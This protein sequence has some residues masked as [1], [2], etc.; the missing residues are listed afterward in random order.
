MSI[1]KKSV[2]F[3]LSAII[4]GCTPQKHAD[5]TSDNSRYQW[6][7]IRQ[8]I[9]R[10]PEHALAMVDTAYMK[11][12]ADVNYANWMRA[13]IYYSSPKVTD[14]DKARELCIA[15][16]ENKNPEPDSLRKLRTLSLLTGVC[17]NHPDTYQDAVHYAIRGAEMAHRAGDIQQE[18]DF[19]FQAGK[20]M[21]RL[22][23]G[24]GFE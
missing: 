23:R 3:L 6:E 1:M 17:A 7:N 15:I 12:L 19:Y 21:E 20:V 13:V 4:L 9:L 24:S 10:E 14:Y 8:Y 18:A 16:L 11:G 5:N 22:Q 2:I